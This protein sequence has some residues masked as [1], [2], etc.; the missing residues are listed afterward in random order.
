MSMEEK[1]FKINEN[2]S[3]GMKDFAKQLN[4]CEKEKEGRLGEGSGYYSNSGKLVIYKCFN[5]QLS[6][7]VLDEKDNIKELII[8]N[9]ELEEDSYKI[10]EQLSSLKRLV[11]ESVGTYVLEL[12]PDNLTELTELTINLV[13]NAELPQWVCKL[14]SLKRLDISRTRIDHIDD[15]SDNFWEK[16]ELINVSNTDVKN[17]PEFSKKN[18]ACSNLEMLS[19]ANTGISGIPRAYITKK[20]RYLDCN[21]TQVTQSQAYLQE[22]FQ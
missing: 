1:M 12:N 18:F 22:V 19:I 16:C 13:S 2:C 6:E 17:L 8:R 10:I 14:K 15:L 7:G 9:N 11:L 5:E 3:E 20:L 21:N 4:L